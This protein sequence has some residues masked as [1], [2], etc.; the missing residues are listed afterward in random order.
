MIEWLN[1]WDK[2]SKV[3]ESNDKKML[4]KRSLLF[5]TD[6]NYTTTIV[7]IVKLSNKREQ[8]KAPA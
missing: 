4:G 1:K 8:E 3:E 7:N 6:M 2:L 5:Y